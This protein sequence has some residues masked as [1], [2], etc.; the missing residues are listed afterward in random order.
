MLSVLLRRFG[1]GVLV[2]LGSG[3]AVALAV[4][5][6]PD[7]TTDATVLRQWWTYLQVLVTFDYGTVDS[8]NRSM[9]TLL[10]H[11]GQV[12]LTL[13]SGA[14]LLMLALGVP[15][16]VGRALWP[17]SQGIRW[18]TGLGHTLSSVPILVWAFA[19]L[20]LS[21]AVF[22]VAPNFGNLQGA[23]TG[24]ALLIYAVPIAALA[25]GDGVL[26]DIIRHVRSE[27]E[28]E[29]EQTYVRAL[30]ARKAPVLRHVWRGIVGPVF[31]VVSNKIAYLI[32]GTIVVEY[33]FGARGLAYQIY[34][35]IEAT[36]EYEVVLAAT[37]VFVAVTVLLKLLSEFVALMADPR[38]RAA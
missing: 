22:G 34:W 16:G 29:V 10:W 28:Q 1:F 5:F 15:L 4:S 14:L 3:S 33:V 23:S 11:R 26:S 2:L 21:T 37:L 24:E 35:S 18:A 31:T 32:S 6:V 9:S 30:R 8:V 7:S 25:L 20:A 36:K 13:I 19:L 27:A 17:E 38:L 12:T